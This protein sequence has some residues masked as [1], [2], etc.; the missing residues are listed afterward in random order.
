VYYD[1]VGHIPKAT[2]DM[3]DRE[4]LAMMAARHTSTNEDDLDE[5]QRQRLSPSRCQSN[6]IEAYTK[7]IQAVE[8]MLKLDRLRQ[9]SAM[10]NMLNKHER[11]ARL[12]G[13]YGI[14]SNNFRMKRA[15]SLPNTINNVSLPPIPPSSQHHRYSNIHSSGIPQSTSSNNNENLSNNKIMEMSTSASS[16]YSSMVNSL[17][18]PMMEYGGRLMNCIDEEQQNQLSEI[19]KEPVRSFTVPET[20]HSTNQHFSPKPVSPRLLSD[21]SQDEEN[22][23]QYSCANHLFNENEHCTPRRQPQQAGTI[24]LEFN[25]SHA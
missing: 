16:G 12:S 20:L 13:V 18:S 4:T 23:V 11:A 19:L 6:Y 3:E 15:V 17:V 7:S 22:N 8:W 10:F 9:E 24:N 21:L 25:E 2:L 1:L 5:K 14:P